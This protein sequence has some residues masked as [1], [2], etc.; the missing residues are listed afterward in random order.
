MLSDHG[1][2]FNIVCEVQAKPDYVRRAIR[3]AEREG[4]A[5]LSHRARVELLQLYREGLEIGLQ[6]VVPLWAAT[7]IR[8]LL[9]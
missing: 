9:F 3:L 8:E 5:G 2:G 6:E 4:D 1:S 7:Q